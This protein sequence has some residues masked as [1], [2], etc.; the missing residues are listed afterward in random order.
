MFVC[1]FGVYA[2]D[3]CQQFQWSQKSYRD[4]SLFERKKER[5]FRIWSHC[6]LDFD[7]ENVLSSAKCH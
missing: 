4:L 6:D 7:L 3:T 2:S 1:L 5:K